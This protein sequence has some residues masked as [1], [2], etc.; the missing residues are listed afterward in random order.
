MWR[1]AGRSPVL[2][3]M[4]A[5]KWCVADGLSYACMSGRKPAEEATA[6]TAESSQSYR[7][8][9]HARTGKPNRPHGTYIS[10]G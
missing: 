1:G 6:Q 2:P 5:S 7:A 4:R 3:A 9:Q 10:G 8:D